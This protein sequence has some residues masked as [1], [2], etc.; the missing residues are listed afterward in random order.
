MSLISLIMLSIVWLGNGDMPAG[1]SIPWR[2]APRGSADVAEPVETIARMCRL[3]VPLG[4]VGES[5]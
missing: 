3:V 2:L 1:W 5:P 4:P